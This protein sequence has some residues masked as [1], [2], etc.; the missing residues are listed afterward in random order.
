MAK[1]KA[2]KAAARQ[3]VI[4]S[5]GVPVHE[6]LTP[7]RAERIR[8]SLADPTITNERRAQLTEWLKAVEAE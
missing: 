5:N 2:T 3:V 4:D 7:S 6:R 8:L 1:R